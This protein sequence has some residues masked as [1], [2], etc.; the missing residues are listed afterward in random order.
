[1][2]R[3]HLCILPAFCDGLEF[4]KLMVI[5]DRKSVR[6]VSWMMASELAAVLCARHVWVCGSRLPQCV[7]FAFLIFHSVFFSFFFCCFDSWRVNRHQDKH[8]QRR[9]IRTMQ[10]VLHFRNVPSTHNT[11]THTNADVREALNQDEL[12]ISRKSHVMCY[13]ECIAMMARH[14]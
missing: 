4:S 8:K 10:H 14:V 2:A 5:G 12:V 11:Q 1:M 7:L 13:L 6:S 3:P 9:Q